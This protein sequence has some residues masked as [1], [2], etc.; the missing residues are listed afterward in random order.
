MSNNAVGRCHCCDCFHV[1]LAQFGKEIQRIW[2]KRDGIGAI[3][4]V[5]FALRSH[6]AICAMCSLGAQSKPAHQRDTSD[7]KPLRD[8]PVREA[9]ID[10]TWKLPDIEM[11]TAN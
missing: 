7:A 5:Q 9:T 8:N 2:R 4:I 3:E 11:I 6:R 10:K 1:R